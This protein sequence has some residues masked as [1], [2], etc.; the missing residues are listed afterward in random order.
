VCL[1]V[2]SLRYSADAPYCYLWPAQVYN[3]FFI[4]FIKNTILGEKV[5]KLKICL[6]IF[7]KI[8]SETF[9]I[10]QGNKRVILKYAYWLSCE[11]PCTLVRF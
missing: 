9:F 1:Y 2:C 4:Y 10:L 11:V 8:L 6:S 5:I 3:I 7:S